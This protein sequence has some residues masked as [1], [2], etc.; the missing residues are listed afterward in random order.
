MA[1]D[2]GTTSSR[3]L[4][5][6][7]KGQILG[8][9]QKGVTPYYPQPGWV[10]QDPEEIWQTQLA[11]AREALAQAG[12]AASDL[13]AIGIAN[14]RET[15][16]VWDAVTGRTLGNAV[17]WQCRRT[18][19]RCEELKAAGLEPVIAAKTGLRLDP[20]FTAT[21]FEWLI[22]HIS[23]VSHMATKGRLRGGTVDSFLIWR[24]TGGKRHVTDHTNASRTMLLALD[25]LTWDDELLGIFGVP[26][27]MLP[28]PVPSCG[29]LGETDPSV[30]GLPVPIAG[31]AGDQQAALF[32]QG[33]FC[34]G[35][36]KN[37]YGTGCFL[38]MNV[39]SRPAPATHGVLSTVAW[40]GVPS[41][42]PCPTTSLGPPSNA[43]SRGLLTGPAVYALEGSVFMAGGAVQW[44]AEALGLIEK[45][46]HIGPL[47]AKAQDNG[48][49]YFVPALTGLGAPYWDPYARGLFIGL[50][51]AT[52][53]EHLARAVEEAICFQTKAVVE[54][55]EAA[56][57]I[58]IKSL[59][60]DGGA[61][62][63]DFLLQL[64][65]DLLGVPVI[66]RQMRESTALGAAMLAG[67][68]VEFWAPE[69]L[70]ELSGE[71]QAF[72]PG[73]TEEMR[74]ALYQ[75]WQQAVERA[76][77]W[78]PKEIAQDAS[79]PKSSE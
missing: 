73:M 28:E 62:G 14:Q 9:S 15:A 56:S 39:G 20:Y 22:S 57:G 43:S 68:A 50:T 40:T 23:E 64:Q 24:L 10:E 5:F 32:G 16:V 66:R 70:A 30:F 46:A 27:A 6:D 26:L 59:R 38:L 67:L 49:V 36:C 33:A 29:V 58:Q 65:A 2:Q 21:K 7:R 79:Q 42:G 17:V 74:A 69:E 18:A 44:L 60:A 4:V 78:A 45:P 12:L 34:S 71:S 55:M 72:A 31:V 11:C 13:A 75:R 54:A 1:L 51:R 3:A 48:G 25:T 41:L 37:T 8:V 53:R 19:P 35:D 61:A 63:D 47:A 77:S 52:R 76:V